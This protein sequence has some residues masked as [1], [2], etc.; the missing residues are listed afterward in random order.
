MLKL[1]YGTTG[2][3]KSSAM[4][5]KIRDEAEQIRASGDNRKICVIVPDQFT[6]EYE[7]M[8]YN[9]MGCA[10][11][12]SGSTEVWS[13]SRLVRDIFSKTAAPEGDAADPTVK[14]AIMYR[15]IKQAS[16]E[17]ALHYYKKQAARPNFTATALTMISELVHSG[18]T[19]EI[20]AE[21]AEKAPENIRE[22]LTDV[23]VIYA[24]FS[25]ALG[26]TGLRDP[27]LD[28]RM[29]A[30]NAVESGY[31]SG[32][33]IY[34]DEFKSFTGD[35][36]ELIR[37][38]LPNCAEL[39]VCLTSENLSDEGYS[40]F[41]AVNR[42]A[43][44]LLYLAEKS[45]VKAETVRFS[46]CT[47]YSSAGLAAL[48]E[49]LMRLP[50]AKNAAS[51]EAVTVIAA[52]DIYGECDYICAE[53][54]RL[55][56]E[57]KELRYRDIAVLDRS[58]NEDISILAPCFERYDIPF[59][60][61][62]KQSAAHKRLMIMINNA[63]ELAAS[64]KISTEVLF[65]YAKTGLA[66]PPKEFEKDGNKLLLYTLEPKKELLQLENY[67]Y[68]WD[69]DGEM[70]EKPFPDEKMEEIKNELLK[71]ILALRNDCRDKT[72]TEICAA[73]RRFMAS[74]PAEDNL[75][76]FT[77]SSP[78][79]TEASG[80]AVLDEK[81]EKRENERL[82]SELDAIL[83]GLER[84]LPDKISLSEFREIFTLSA[85]GITLSVPPETL[86]CVS[87]QQSDLARLSDPK[88]VF[89]MHANDGVFPF[90]TGESLTFSER[91]REFFRSCD[92]DLSGDI[93][94]RIEEERFNAFKALCSPSEKLYVSYSSAASNGSPMYPSALIAEICGI[95]QNV[96]RINTDNLD[97][98]F[99]CRTEEA[100][101]A[102][103]TA[104]FDAS[105]ENFATV[106]AELSKNP[107][108]KG[109]FEYIDSVNTGSEHKIN[110]KELIKKLYN[111][112][113]DISPSRFEDFSKCPFMF[114]CKKGLGI[115]PLQKK[116][117]NPMIRGN[118]I[119]KC[120]Q[121]IFTKYSKEDFTALT[122]DDIL[123]E[124]RGSVNGY[125]DSDLG[126]GFA[127]S[128]GF[129]FYMEIIIKLV[130]KVILNMQHG[131]TLSS[132]V[133]VACELPMG[134]PDKNETAAKEKFS[135]V[136][137]EKYAE[138]CKKLAEE[139]AKPIE[140]KTDD[141][142]EVSF[143]G[144]A[145]RAD[146]F[147]NQNDGGKIYLRII[148]YKTG[149]KEFV[150][151][152]LDLGIN[153]Q[154][155]FYLWAITRRDGDNDSCFNA[156]GALYSPMKA[157]KL[158]EPKK[159]KNNDPAVIER[160]AFRFSGEILNT[161]SVLKAMQNDLDTLN[162][163][164][165]LYIPAVFAPDTGNAAVGD[166]HYSNVF[167][168]EELNSDI[169]KAD[170]LLRSF[171]EAL[172]NGVIN[173]SPLE[174]K[175]LNC[176]LPCTNCDYSEICGNYSDPKIRDSSLFSAAFTKDADDTSGD[177]AGSD[178]DN[179][180]AAAQTANTDAENE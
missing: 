154:M 50:R 147:I 115:Y 26:D 104:G 3:G 98:L 62:K 54:K 131:M 57:N 60:S 171:A 88:I 101:Y 103:A 149:A 45:N 100:A 150:R 67:C 7:R 177:D 18:I 134:K 9:A 125:I 11:F 156:A 51:G 126:G 132:F 56:S 83:A 24:R 94:N 180:E 120:M 29:A 124:V 111:G 16:A 95:L 22:K 105:D 33:S 108:Y 59:Y 64:R 99:F 153:M 127:K 102:A 151:E 46:E 19:P 42:T 73:I 10:L 35:Q 32:M 48:S 141:G 162:N 175:K 161:E 148:D 138:I 92:H 14:T 172:E 84:A 159:G 8:L 130:V 13:F 142:F 93:K 122:E 30:E 110:D 15:V 90:V 28:S 74:I 109:R 41:T 58:M 38:M 136:N 43:A 6:F 168:P 167:S 170:I 63:L 53:I 123:A 135:S 139:A 143:S 96:N 155:F 114:F 66:N 87:A 27:L 61:D 81:L 164:N 70:W 20:M 34:M 112:K 55:I 173:A 4:M 128:A 68:I 144:T 85:A 39:T 152:Q 121:D 97:M 91:E 65:R 118:A 165:E 44:R 145:D 179:A 160:D 107:I 163:D 77:V 12:N 21:L 158:T 129:D 140:V 86:D 113:A 47:R 52:P 75:L 36:Y 119:H 23:A 174:N 31:F 5:K 176:L 79:D 49:K 78:D 76:N 17:D 37:A 157:P 116:D 137:N 117:L 80:R 166:K 72:G 133:P 146:I 1:F 82:L 69:I 106:R 89:V 178:A 71:P 2:T 25:K 169:A 40:P